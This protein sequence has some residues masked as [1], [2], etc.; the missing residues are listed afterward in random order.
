MHAVGVGRSAR[1]Y[2]KLKDLDGSVENCAVK[3]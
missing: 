1:F 3:A 2:L